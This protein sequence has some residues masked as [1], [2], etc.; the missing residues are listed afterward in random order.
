M[1]YTPN[2]QSRMSKGSGRMLSTY[3]GGR[4]TGNRENFDKERREGHI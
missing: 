4:T 3:E 2:D 1:G